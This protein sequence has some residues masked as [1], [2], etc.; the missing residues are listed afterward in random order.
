MFELKNANFADDFH[1]FGL[2][3]TEKQLEFYVDNAI[4]GCLN[5]EDMP[6]FHKPHFILLNIAVGGNW[7]GP[8]DDTTVFPQEYIVDWIRY[9]K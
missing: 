1:I 8:P 7:L 9:Y 4:F 6:E 2:T 5:I 3:W